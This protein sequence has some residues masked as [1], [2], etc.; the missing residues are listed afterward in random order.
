MESEQNRNITGLE[1]DAYS[2]IEGE[3]NQ[4]TVVSYDTA[5]AQQELQQTS[6]STARVIVSI[7]VN[8]IQKNGLPTEESWQYLQRMERHLIRL[9]SNAGVDCRLGGR[10][11]SGGKEELVFLTTAEQSFIAAIAEMLEKDTAYRMELQFEEGVCYYEDQVK[12][13]PRDW[14]QIQDRKQIAEM[15]QAG[16][17]P[18]GEQRVLHSFAG[19]EQSLERLSAVLQQENFL[20]RSCTGEKLILENRAQL[21]PDLVFA[22]SMKLLDLSEPLG[23]KYLGWS[24][25]SD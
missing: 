15:L 8:Y 17:D 20:E 6:Q 19:E 24:L 21:Y 3:G 9:V 12:P 10:I 4:L 23:V 22:M 16:G 5:L 7:P 14:R 2:R 13:A 1:W 18:T 25:D 11:L